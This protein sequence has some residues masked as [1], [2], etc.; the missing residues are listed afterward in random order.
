M[1]QQDKKIT[2]ADLPWF[3]H[4]IQL[5]R[6]EDYA[7]VIYNETDGNIAQMEWVP[8]PLSSRRT[9]TSREANAKFIVKCVNS[10]EELLQA[11]REAIWFI[12]HVMGKEKRID[13]GKS[14]NIDWARINTALI[15]I[16]KVETLLK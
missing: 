5:P 9:G 10:H 8:F 12:D 16:H 6:S 11:L 13:W 2:H 14:F 1:Q 7:H 15:Q 4:Y 3:E